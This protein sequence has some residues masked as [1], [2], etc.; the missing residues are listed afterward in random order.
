MMKIK[1]DGGYCVVLNDT[2]WGVGATKPLAWYD[3]MKELSESDWNLVFGEGSDGDFRNTFRINDLVILP[4]SSSLCVDVAVEASEDVKWCLFEGV[5]CTRKEVA[6][7]KR[8]QRRLEK[9]NRT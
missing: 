2:I 3:A 1:A 6:S 4:V 9:R 5:C 8:R 7:L